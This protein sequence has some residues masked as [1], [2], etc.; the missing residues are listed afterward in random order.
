MSRLEGRRLLCVVRCWRKCGM[1]N[2]E[3]ADQAG[4]VTSWAR[5]SE[6]HV[7]WRRTSFRVA[8]SLSTAELASALAPP[9][10][11]QY[12][13]QA[14]GWM[15]AERRDAWEGSS[16]VTGRREVQRRLG[17][18]QARIRA[19]DEE[20]AL[21]GAWRMEGSGASAGRRITKQAARRQPRETQPNQGLRRPTPCR[22]PSAE[23]HSRP[24]RWPCQPVLL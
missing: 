17:S 18:Q 3:A 22:G 14:W 15:Q 23:K 19:R 12:C 5:A 10:G 13:R 16:V 7:H 1:W 24:Y 2:G 4:G 9:C 8:S 21:V 11:M 20:R 6:D